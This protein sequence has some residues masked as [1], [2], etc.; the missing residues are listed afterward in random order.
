VGHSIRYVGGVQKVTR[1]L[2]LG[3]VIDRGR[4]EAAHSAVDGGPMARALGA[5]LGAGYPV[6]GPSIGALSGWL[7]AL[8][9]RGHAAARDRA[10]LRALLAER[11]EGLSIDARPAELRRFARDER[12]RVALR[13][14]LPL[15]LGGADVDVTAG[16]LSALADV[17]ID[18]AYRIALEE[19][20]ARYGPILT[21]N[22]P[23]RFVVLGMGKLGGNELN[24]GSDVDLIYFYD[25]DED[26][27]TEHAPFELWT[28]VARRLT[29]LLDEPAEDGFVWRVD[30]RL[31]PEGST[32][33]IVNSVAAAERYYESFGRLWER[34]A[35]LRARPVAGDL[36]LGDEILAMLAPFVWRRRVDPRVAIEMSALV[37]R[38]RVELSEDGDR[39]LKLGPGGI[40]EAEFFVQTLQLVWGGREPR[41]RARGTLEGLSRLRAAGLVSDREAREVGGA[42]IALRRAEHLVQSATGVQTHALPPPGE[43]LE[44]FSRALGFTDSTAFSTDLSRR[45]RAVAA[46]F[47]SLLPEAKPSPSRWLEAIAALERGRGE[48]FLAAVRRAAS[49]SFGQ[50]EGERSDDLGRDLFELSRHADGP[51]GLRTR[52]RFPQLAETV[53][54]AVLDAADPDQAARYLMTFFARVGQAG[55]YVRLLGDDPR[56]VKKLVE[57]IGSSAFVGDAIASNPELGDAVV[58]ASSGAAF[59]ASSVAIEISNAITIEAAAASSE[60]EPEEVLV[61]ALRG[62]KARAT[63]VIALADLAGELET[64][65]VTSAL[66]ALADA[67][68]DA[69]VRF[70]LA[71]PDQPADVARLGDTIPRGLSVIAMGKLGG[72]EIGY[73]SDL[74]VFFLFDPDAA[75]AGKDPDAYFA[76]AARRV[77]RLVSASHRAGPGYELDTRLRPSGNQGLLVTSIDALSRYHGVGDGPGVRAAAWERLALLRARAAAGDPELGERAKQVLEA[78]AY[79]GAFDRAEMAA[80]ILRLRARLAAELSQ[81][82]EDRYDL[83]LGRGGLLEIEFAVQFLQLCH[84]ADRRVRTTETTRAI[85]AL[86][87][88]GHLSADKAAALSDGYAFLRRLEQ[89]IHIVHATSAHLLEE[90]AAG[91]ATLA[92]RMGV[93]DRRGAGASQ[94]LL[95]RYREVTARA[96]DAF[97]QLVR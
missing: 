24:A 26:A 35:M 33:P 13:E 81:E 22:G 51:L 84:G 11:F 80:E 95:A 57:A 60:D 59:S 46:R 15:S 83:K 36:E 14:L 67:S 68:L 92:R 21:R 4:A 16:E 62:A 1:V 55:V 75:P 45:R 65:D 43:D 50:D 87:S 97:T 18:A 6:L 38:S 54:D 96:H 86:A 20:T 72:R 47:A 73:G 32:G 74:D 42:Y 94:A 78:A 34:A 61:T 77:I 71:P 82:R 48:A 39:D 9:E 41:V 19:V 88:L 17:T 69:A 76:R 85:T 40:R 90:R 25:S 10:T 52:E 66:A 8:E 49:E 30:L 63:V 56:A 7:R 53:L 2:E 70:A 58:F 27:G 23:G 12:V 29:S 28:R 5:V 79:D 89:R 64:R 91:L 31:R 93:R 3:R 37:E 44:R